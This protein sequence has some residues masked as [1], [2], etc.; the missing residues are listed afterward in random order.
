MCSAENVFQPLSCAVGGDFWRV[1][2]HFL[3]LLD[4]RGSFLQHMRFTHSECCV[5]QQE[6]SLQLIFLSTIALSNYFLLWSHPMSN[7]VR[8]VLI[9]NVMECGKLELAE[10]V[11]FTSC[12]LSLVGAGKSLWVGLRE[13]GRRLLSGEVNGA[14]EHISKD[15][16]GAVGLEGNSS[17]QWILK[18]DK[19]G[20]EPWHQD[21]SFSY[22]PPSPLYSPLVPVIFDTN[23]LRKVIVDRVPLPKKRRPEWK[24]I[25]WNLIWL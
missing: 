1:W 5:D 14:L 24:T 8:K 10:V 12:P 18:L 17:T 13:S 20:H 16:G 23:D 15:D 11:E 6:Q 19:F 25:D 3:A 4:T 21:L 2:W 9:L 7:R 22:S